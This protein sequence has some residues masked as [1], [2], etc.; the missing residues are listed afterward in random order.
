[1]SPEAPFLP[2]LLTA[3]VT[4]SEYICWFGF[5]NKLTLYEIIMFFLKEINL[6]YNLLVKQQ[7]FSN[8]LD[9]I[10]DVSVIH[11]YILSEV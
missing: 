2:Y 11:M 7:C 8:W 6:H 9:A 5:Q 4:A 1:M 3:N 10:S